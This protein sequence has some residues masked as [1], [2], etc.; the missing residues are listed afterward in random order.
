MALPIPLKSGWVEF[1]VFVS[2]GSAGAI[3]SLNRRST[4]KHSLQLETI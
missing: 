4:H 3:G 2:T 1:V